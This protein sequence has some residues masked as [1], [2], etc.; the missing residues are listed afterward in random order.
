MRFEFTIPEGMKAVKVELVPE[1]TE[2]NTEERL[3]RLE[4]HS[5]TQLDLILHNGAR[6]EAMAD[7]MED[8]EGRTSS[9]PFEP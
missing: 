6:L 2:H 3:T 9:G 7:R 8:V 1:H 5:D 4:R